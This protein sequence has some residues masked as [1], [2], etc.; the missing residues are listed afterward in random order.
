MLNP[1]ISFA[2]LCVAVL[3]LKLIKKG[4]QTYFDKGN[5]VGLLSKKCADYTKRSHVY[6]SDS[7]SYVLFFHKILLNI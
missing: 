6:A 4:R 3:S 1:S 7:F 2:K 5:V